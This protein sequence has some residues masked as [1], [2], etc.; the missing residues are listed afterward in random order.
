MHSPGINGEGKLRGQL[1]NPVSQFHILV[2]CILSLF[3]C[4]V[5]LCCPGP[6]WYT[7][8]LYGTI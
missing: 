5:C 4:M 7:S 6:A 2:Y 3:N 1:A 8:Y